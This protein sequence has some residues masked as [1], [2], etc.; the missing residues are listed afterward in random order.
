[1]EQV[2]SAVLVNQ[3]SEIARLGE[4]AARFGEANRISTDD[5]LAINLVLDEVVINVVK[6]AFTDGQEHQIP[7]RLAREGNVVTIRVDDDGRPFNPLE[8]PPPNLDLPIEERPI[9]GLGIHIVKSTCDGIEYRR[10]GGRN[11]L[12]MTKTVTPIE[13][14]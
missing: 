13:G 7:V 11:I 12:T 4:L 2:L 6:Y 3:L 5:V 8:A 9:G 14:A 10:E 1:M